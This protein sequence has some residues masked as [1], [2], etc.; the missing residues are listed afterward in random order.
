MTLPEGW[1]HTGDP[2]ALHGAELQLVAD[3]EH[4]AH[5]VLRCTGACALS[6]EADGIAP[7]AQHDATE[8]W[9]AYRIGD[10][11]LL[12]DASPESWGPEAAVDLLLALGRVFDEAEIAHGALDPWRILLHSHGAVS[13]I[14][15]GLPV[16]PERAGPVGARF[17][18]P[19]VR[20]GEPADVRADV[21]AAGMCAAMM[22]VDGSVDAPALAEHEFGPEPLKALILDCVAS[23]PSERPASGAELVQ[24]A[25]EVRHGPPKK[26]SEPEPSGVLRNIGRTFAREW[27]RALPRPVRG[28]QAQAA[29]ARG[30]RHRV[31]DGRA[32][33][34]RPGRAR[35]RTAC[36]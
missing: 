30:G 7:L 12:A 19:E 21:F 6:I 34:G 4:T 27:G 11:M 10:G 24:R 1:T 15:Y 29:T 33:R 26:P 28:P 36:R 18:A 13:V 23:D 32:H 14:G 31:R 22:L 35:R 16:D 25:R 8:G 9:F 17:V 5:A 3:A 20:D 2:I